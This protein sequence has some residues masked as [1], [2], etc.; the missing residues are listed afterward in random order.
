MH[1]AR[2][3]APWSRKERT[4]DAL[5][6]IA[7]G[8][9][10][11]R[12]RVCALAACIAISLLGCG[13]PRDPGGAPRLVA[14][15][16]TVLEEPDS[17][18]IA[19]PGLGFAVD[20]AG[21]FYVTDPFQVRLT[22][23]DAHGSLVR[24][25][26]RR[27][28]GPGEFRSFQ[29]FTWVSDSI[30]VQAS[31]RGF[32][33]FNNSTGRYLGEIGFGRA[34]SSAPALDGDRLYI[35]LTTL[36]DTTGAAIVDRREFLRRLTTSDSATV[37]PT[38]IG[39]PPEYLAYR[40][41]RSWTYNSVVA[42]D[43]SVM[44]GYAGVPYLVVY[45]TAGTSTDTLWVPAIRRRGFPDG[46]L[47]P[48]QE[49]R[50]LTTAELVASISYLNG[51]WRSSHGDFILWYQ[52]NWM[53]PEGTNPPLFG[54]AWVSVLRR[55]LRSACVDAPVAVPGTEWPVLAFHDDMILSLDQRIHADSTSAST[56]IAAFSVDTTACTWLPVR[57]S[58]LK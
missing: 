32:K 12:S 45:D 58:T 21:N 35:P 18:F 49:G 20:S 31:G 23:Y 37:A 43:D 4:V 51:I 8:A 40:A 14:R 13:A 44:F 25:I 7:G 46:W 16:T 42:W 27:G 6:G 39:F 22:K 5:P 11:S 10:R 54:K 15:D 19:E 41:L 56:V 17:S 53:N 24:V 2:F 48:Y 30:L 50:P 34:W 26:A 1:V 3:V 9:I 52:E 55:D 28:P 33:A 36:T 57:H 29:P 47:H 38:H